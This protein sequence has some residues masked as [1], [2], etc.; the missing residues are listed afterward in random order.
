[1]PLRL[2]P[3][4]TKYKFVA[5]RYICLALSIAVIAGTIGLMLT[6][7]LNL[8]IDFT[9][10]ALIEFKTEKPADI[11]KLRS[12]LGNASIQTAGDNDVLIVRIPLATNDSEEQAKIVKEVK[13][14]IIDAAGSNVDFRKVDYVGPQAGAELITKAIYATLGS[15]LAIMV[16]IWFRFEWQYGIGGLLALVHDAIAVVGF[17]AL[18]GI[19][20][21]LTSVA[22]ILT[23]I[24]YSINDSV[25]IYD[26]VRENIRKYKKMSLADLL[27]LSVNETLS[28]TI[29]TSSTTLIALTALI[30]WGGD[31]LASFSWGTFFGILVGTYSSIYVSAI[32]LLVVKPNRSL[33]A[34]KETRSATIPEG[35]TN[36]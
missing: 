31:V 12:E 28:R 27:D 26:R 9:G 19:E 23:V 18:T 3:A 1:M 29:M 4:N 21:N 13:A 2:I 32:V 8:G 25:V 33:E 7:G 15:F 5:K 22:A 14:H 17:Y 16:Y 11:Q 20:F 30:V 36:D 35:F 6:K 24:G 34:K 10:G